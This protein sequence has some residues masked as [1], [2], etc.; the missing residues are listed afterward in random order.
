MNPSLALALGALAIGGGLGTEEEDAGITLAQADES[1][2]DEDLLNE[3]LDGELN[4][5]ADA[6]VEA[7][8]AGV[9]SPPPLQLTQP[10]SF[11]AP[12]PAGRV[13]GRIAMGPPGY[14]VALGTFEYALQPRL[15]VG[16]DVGVDG[17]QPVL[18]AGSRYAL[19][20]DRFSEVYVSVGGTLGMYLGSTAYPELRI[21]AAVG[22]SLASRVDLQAMG[23]VALALGG[24]NPSF[25]PSFVR[26]LEYLVAAQAAYRLGDKA[27]VMLE[28]N[29]RI[30]PTE[31][32][33]EPPEGT[34]STQVFSALVAGGRYRVTDDLS[35]G[36]GVRIPVFHQYRWDYYW[37][38]GV[39][40]S[41]LL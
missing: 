20:A 2:I 32:G 21:E 23:T 9:T 1:D 13:A 5:D 17:S 6:E 14:A 30:E 25:G 41:W 28:S 19:V 24:T 31:L 7:L 22:K 15:S 3:E 4:R 34:G 37:S 18:R 40:A 35:V 27:A 10:L 16:G 26:D 39:T 33:M 38:A 12:L 29:T 11:N 8:K 36:A